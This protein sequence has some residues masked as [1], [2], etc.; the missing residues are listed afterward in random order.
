MLY[1][2]NW[3]HVNTE[4]A[5]RCLN[6]RSELS[7]GHGGVMFIQRRS[8]LIT[9]LHFQHSGFITEA[10]YALLRGPAVVTR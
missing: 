4:R 3:F 1:F 8:V 9:H 6:A 7:H 2:L 5:P 10:L